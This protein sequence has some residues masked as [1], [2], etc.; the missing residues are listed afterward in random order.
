MLDLLG[1]PNYM[2]VC[3]FYELKADTIIKGVP[4]YKDPEY[5]G[6]S[7]GIIVRNN[8][9]PFKTSEFGID[10]S[11]S[12]LAYLDVT[13]LNVDNLLIKEGYYLKDEN[14]QLYLIVALQVLDNLLVLALQEKKDLVG[15][16]WKK[17]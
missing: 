6:A 10:I 9:N 3:Q 4:T 17:E 15:K 5:L 2:M 14:N 12:F 7:E 8:I 1:F 11:Y 16:A 13:S